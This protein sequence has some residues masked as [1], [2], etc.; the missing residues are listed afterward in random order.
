MPSTLPMSI[1]IVNC[2][3]RTKIVSPFDRFRM[4]KN[5][6]LSNVRCNPFSFTW[7][8]K[9][10]KSSSEHEQGVALTASHSRQL[11]DLLIII[12]FVCTLIEINFTPLHFNR[13]YSVH[14]LPK[15]AWSINF[16][17]LRMVV[18]R[19]GH[20]CIPTWITRQNVCISL[21]LWR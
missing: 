10:N 11:I 12:A 7:N 21:T 8:T 4:H 14:H 20:T 13:A 17:W 15:N 9:S 5:F 18:W 6:A 3:R 2:V 16:L 1:H 19:Y